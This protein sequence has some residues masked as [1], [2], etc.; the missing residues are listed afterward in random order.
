MKLARILVAALAVALIGLCAGC[1]TNGAQPLSPAQIAAVACPPIQAAITQFEVLDASLPG[2]PVAQKAEAD[3]QALQPIVAAACATGATITSTNIQAVA[4]TVL[5]ALGRILATLPIPAV[6]Q[7]QIQAGLVAAEIAV[8][9]AGVI[10]QQIQAAKSAPA[11]ASTV[12]PPL[13]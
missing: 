8:G 7:A 3:L 13:Q 5:P 4:Q 6:Q 10:E 9:A 11:S 2:V 12:A 1:A